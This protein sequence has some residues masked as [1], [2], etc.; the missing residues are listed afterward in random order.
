MCVGTGLSF[1][2]E[3]L[4]AVMSLEIAYQRGWH[5]LWI[6]ST[7]IYCRSFFLPFFTGTLALCRDDWA[8]SL[9]FTAKESRLLK[10]WQMLTC[11]WSFAHPEIVSLVNQDL[12][13]P[14]QSIIIV[15]WFFCFVLSSLF[16]LFFLC[17]GKSLPHLVI[18]STGFYFYQ[19]DYTFFPLGFTVKLIL[20][21][22]DLC[23]FLY[24][25][26]SC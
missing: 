22:L 26:K 23:L 9:T 12:L 15:L 18:F 10:W 14:F 5:H 11:W 6:E 20:L 2:A 17:R 25:A 3:L 1:E 19:V 8:K 4:A 16:R 21:R 13:L 24:Y 7:Y